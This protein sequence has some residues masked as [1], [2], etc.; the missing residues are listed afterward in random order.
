MLALKENKKM[1]QVYAMFLSEN[2][3]A[4]VKVPSVLWHCWLAAGRA[5]GL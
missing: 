4:C 2:S 3:V 5:T 1:S